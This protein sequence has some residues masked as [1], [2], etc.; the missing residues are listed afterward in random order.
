MYERALNDKGQQVISVA[1]LNKLVQHLTS[2][3]VSDQEFVKA[4]LLTYGSFS[5]AEK[6]LAKLIERYHTPPSCTGSVQVIKLRV[7]N[8][9]RLWFVLFFIY[10]F[11]FL[12]FI[13]LFFYFFIF[14]FLFFNI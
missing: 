13:F 2:E 4:F 12:F 6:I 9:L 11:I 3:S 8:A 10:L 5:T 7:L 1:T 14:I